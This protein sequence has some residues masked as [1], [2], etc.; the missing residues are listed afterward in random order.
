M[1]APT[2]TMD[3]MADAAAAAARAKLAA[4]LLGHDLST[5]PLANPFLPIHASAVLQ[6]VQHLLQEPVPSEGDLEDNVAPV[7]VEKDGGREAE[8]ANT[9]FPEGGIEFHRRPSYANPA[10]WN[11]A[12]STN[13]S[14]TNLNLSTGEEERLADE[15][16][17]G[18]ALSRAASVSS[19]EA[20]GGAVPSLE[21]SDRPQSGQVDAELPSRGRDASAAGRLGREDDLEILATRSEPALSRRATT[22]FADE[23]LGNLEQRLQAAATSSGTL[24]RAPAATLD[25]GYMSDGPRLKILERTPSQR[26][27]ERRPQSAATL[28]ALPSL[29]NIA[30]RGFE[31][32]DWA[33]GAAGGIATRDSLFRGTQAARR[34]SPTTGSVSSGGQRLTRPSSSVEC[35]G[36][37]T[38]PPTRLSTAFPCETTTSAE[39]GQ[40]ELSEPSRSPTGFRGP[41]PVRPKSA[42]SAYTSRFDPAVMAAQKAE[43]VKDRPKFIDPDA[44]KPPQVVLMPAPLAGQPQLPAQPPRPEGPDP[45]DDAGSSVFEDGEDDDE[46]PPGLQ[47]PKRPA[48]ALYG[49]SLLD[50]MAERKALLK[51]QQR[52]YVPGSDGRRQMFDLHAPDAQQ[53]VLRDPS[54]ATL[55]ER[56]RPDDPV[57]VDDSPRRRSGA[58][59]ATLADRK[60]VQS[61]FGPDMLYQRELAMAKELEALE[62]RERAA[63]EELEAL[64]RD[65]AE[66]RKVRNKL[67]KG[68][69]AKKRKARGKRGEKK[70]VEHAAATAVEAAAPTEWVGPLERDRAEVFEPEQSYLEQ[71]P[72]DTLE[73]PQPRHSIAPSLS[74]PRGLGNAGIPASSSDWFRTDEERAEAVE[75]DTSDEEDGADAYR[76]RPLSSLAPYDACHPRLVV[77]T[78]SFGSDDTSTRASEREKELCAGSP[79]RRLPSPGEPS[80]L[81]HDAAS[82]ADTEDDRPLGHRFLLTGDAVARTADRYAAAESE[83]EEPLGK[84][85]SR[86][87]LPRIAA[88]SMLQLPVEDERDRIDDD[89]DGIRLV[90]RTNALRGRFANIPTPEEGDDDDE[91]EKPLGARFST[92]IAD[93]DEVPLGL[94]RLSLA[95]QAIPTVPTATLHAVDDDGRS[96][97]T[98]S[99]EE[100]LGLRTGAAPTG[101]RALG[102][103]HNG[104]F[105]PNVPAMNVYPGISP[106]M[107]IPA[108][109]PVYSMPAAPF[110][111][112][113]VPAGPFPTHHLAHQLGRPPSPL[114]APMHLAMAEMQMQAALHHSQAAAAATFGPGASIDQWRKSVQP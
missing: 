94:H 40:A 45:S 106:Y 22:T 36:V 12:V 5:D 59:R 1:M 62:Q 111:P 84:R 37:S 4:A 72:K 41:D 53:Q 50:V 21:A 39:H 67:R 46:V 75:A 49:R 66:Q 95:A 19:P 3:T 54:A 64:K 102:Y 90:D 57:I 29:N 98:D 58:P 38:R 65:E 43:L 17:L 55:T 76:P 110:F 60:A 32:G 33:S 78:F 31:E 101:L 26:R 105:P 23:V 20:P 97:A 108:P 114:Q 82:I 48:G 96:I 107:L 6:P 71:A 109:P 91:D 86:F 2:T 100:P 85:F 28:P 7:L 88:G 34:K 35:Y 112:G 61:I 92:M 63:R 11:A 104:A 27:C 113:S 77:R 73:P 13:P 81:G 80:S 51:G 79:V 10:S 87:S 89:D 24:E 9:L 44:G 25:D 52:A 47:E 70:T 16:G 83:D 30:G 18:E 8:T 69:A 56:V 68:D 42:M 103:P 99:D 14:L 15:W 74:V 93:A